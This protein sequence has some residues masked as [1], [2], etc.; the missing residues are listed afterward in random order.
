MH[1]TI[2]KILK[3]VKPGK[4]QSVGYMQIIPLISDIVDN[5]FSPPNEIYTAT[6]N[7]GT[8]EVENRGKSM[9]ILPFGAGILTEKAAQNHA[10]PITKLLDTNK[11][12]RID[13]A[14]CIQQ[15][16]GGLI[17]SGKHTMTI[18]PWSLKEAAIMTKDVR[19]YNKL[20][21]AITQ[22]ND[23]LGLMRTGHLEL[24]L[25]KF[26]DE[27]QTFIAEF[28][29]VPNQVGAIIIMNGNVVGIERAPNYEFWKEIWKP[30]IR[31]CYGSLAITYAKDDEKNPI[32]PKTRVPLK[33][34]G[35]KSISDI[36]KALKTANDIEEKTIKNI[37]RSFLNEKF[38]SKIEQTKN[39][40]SVESIEN[41]QFRGQIVKR[42]EFIAYASLVTRDYWFKNKK[43]IEADDFKI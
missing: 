31:E 28:E 23:Q 34:T 29:I 14:A 26:K 37:I 38:Q 6:S 20:W 41:K 21:P 43:H 5:K 22:F 25:K 30:L 18:L 40:T 8:L 1:M 32:P 12:V 36:R 42:D 24:Y 17:Q 2:S 19:S 35:I 27:L 16:Q 15:T 9:T 3:G 4:L 7:Y 10:A 33:S 11:R 39:D 13:T